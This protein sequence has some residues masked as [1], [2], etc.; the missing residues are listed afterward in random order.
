M[1][2]EL[3]KG[4]VPVKVSDINDVPG[5]AKD[6][7]QLV[8]QRAY[9]IYEGRG[10][11]DGHDKEDWLQAASEIVA[12]LFVGFMELNG[13]LSIDIGITPTELPVLQVRIEPFRLIA[14]GKRKPLFVWMAQNHPD[15]EPKPNEIFEVVEFP[16]QVEPSGAKATFANGLLEVRIPKAVKRGMSLAARAA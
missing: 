13:D 2:M 14:S 15:K 10:H 11:I 4:P 8:A 1:A 16:V 5:R 6:I 9:A 3:T 12:P 7:H